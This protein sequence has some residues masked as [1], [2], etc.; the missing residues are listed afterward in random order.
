MVWAILSEK[1]V[2]EGRM[3][4]GE[5][6][7]VQYMERTRQY[8]RAMGYEKDYVWAHNE[9]APFMPLKKPLSES[10]VALIT[11]ASDKTKARQ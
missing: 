11:T 4:G 3:S 10:R 6:A 5:N 8:Y 9:D 7:P 1:Y 2:T